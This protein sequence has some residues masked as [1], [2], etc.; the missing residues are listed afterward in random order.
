MLAPL[1]HYVGSGSSHD[2]H[3][4]TKHFVSVVYCPLQADAEPCLMSVS[5]TCSKL[6]GT[7]QTPAPSPRAS[8]VQICLIPLSAEEFPHHHRLLR[9][10]VVQHISSCSS[11]VLFMDMPFPIVNYSARSQLP[12]PHSSAITVFTES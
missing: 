12:I 10:L 11:F 5:S 9:V 2:K 1:G 3:V 8:P 7:V 6:V 4:A